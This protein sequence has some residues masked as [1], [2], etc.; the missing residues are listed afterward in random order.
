[1]E[2]I[3]KIL[4]YETSLKWDFDLSNGTISSGTRMPLLVGPPPEFNGTF[5]VWSPEHLL[6]AAINSC[7][8]TT[9]LSFAKMLH[10]SVERLNVSAKVEFEKREHGFEATKFIITPVIEFQILPD[11]HTLDNLFARTK[12]YC[13][14]SNS[15][16][17]EI[18]VEPRIINK[19]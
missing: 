10:V 17:G 13:F 19:N 18:I 8:A 16:K 7:Y 14:I 9:F 5:N 15:V 1:M 12:K 3:S 4:M 11:Q 6:V 2:A